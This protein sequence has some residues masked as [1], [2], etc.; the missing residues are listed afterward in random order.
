[1]LHTRNSMWNPVSDTSV[2][3]IPSVILDTCHSMA[4][5]TMQPINPH[6]CHAWS[7][8]G[9]SPI[10]SPVYILSQTSCYLFKTPTLKPNITSWFSSHAFSWEAHYHQHNI[11]AI[12]NVSFTYR[13]DINQQAKCSTFTLPTCRKAYCSLQIITRSQPHDTKPSKCMTRTLFCT[14]QE[15]IL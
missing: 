15:P 4:T 8:S 11:G 2:Y 3:I 10:V 9:H 1:M 13:L 14:T 7:I 5:L 6:H 12:I